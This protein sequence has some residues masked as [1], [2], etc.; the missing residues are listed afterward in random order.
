MKKQLVLIKFGGSLITDK[1]TEDAV[2]ADMIERCAEQVEEVK[3]TFPA[4][5]LII[6][7]GVGSFGHI[8]ARKYLLKKGIKPAELFYGMCTIHNNVR[9]LNE[10]VVDRLTERTLSAFSISPSAIFMA[11]DGAVASSFFQPVRQLLSSGCIPMMHGDAVL[12]P[13]R[14]L[15]IMST[16]KVLQTC[17]EDLRELYEEIVVVYCMDVDGIWDENRKVIPVLERDRQ[18]FMHVNDVEDVTGGIE[19]K[20]RS[21]RKAADLADRVYLISGKTQGTLRKAIEG[22]QVGTRIET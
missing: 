20:V 13:V 18:L 3:R 10:M 4:T 5:D 14:G 8:Q 1:R 7:T 11:N 9:K 19:G 16:E 17:L 6:G 12:D 21:A 15:T 22:K 2:R